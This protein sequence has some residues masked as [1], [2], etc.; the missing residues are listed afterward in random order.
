MALDF[1]SLQV[2]EAWHLGGC[3]DLPAYPL[4]LGFL[5]VSTA[6]LVNEVVGI[7]RFLLLSWGSVFLPLALAAPV[8][9]RH[10]VGNDETVFR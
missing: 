6:V 4:L 3:G 8:S 2:M 1:N 5:R 7:C 9:S 10:A